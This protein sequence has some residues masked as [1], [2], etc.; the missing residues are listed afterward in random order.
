[1]NLSQYTPEE[2]QKARIYAAKT[3]R[4]MI[5]AY[6]SKE[7]LVNNPEKWLA[8]TNKIIKDIESGKL[9]GNFTIWQRMNYYLT[10]KCPALL[11]K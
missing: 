5:E 8:D 6:K 11:P 9:D 3:E 4:N 7:F 2:L 10:G 1:M